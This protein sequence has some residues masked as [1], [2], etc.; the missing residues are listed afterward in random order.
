MQL[1]PVK[2]EDRKK[3]DIRSGD[4]IRVWQKIQE[5]K[6]KRSQAFEGL[7]ISRKH[8]SEP[9]ATFTLRKI[10][11]GVGVEMTFPLYSPKIEKVELVSRPKRARRAKLY[12]VRE[13]AAR[14]LRKKIKQSRQI[15]QVLTESAPETKT[16][17]EDKTE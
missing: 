16:E 5:G 14:A 7:L 6:R 4:T 13:R 2:I 1:S 12:Y 3:L 11:S 15:G 17:A 8:G 9:G 10:S